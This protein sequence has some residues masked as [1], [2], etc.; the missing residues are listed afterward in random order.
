MQV[1]TD[2]YTEESSRGCSGPG[3]A[4]ED[5]ARLEIIH[6]HQGEADEGQQL[7]CSRADV[8]LLISVSQQ[9]GQHGLEE[10]QLLALLG[11]RAHSRAAH[12]GGFY[13][14]STL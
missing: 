14:S 9:P 2:S 5:R 13:N 3:A 6:R 4:E 10:L 11:Q 1:G 12:R 8:L 7:G